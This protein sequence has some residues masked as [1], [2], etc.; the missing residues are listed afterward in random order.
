MEEKKLERIILLTALTIF[1][2]GLLSIIFFGVP[3][4]IIL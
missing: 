1:T 3:E 4:E 2:L